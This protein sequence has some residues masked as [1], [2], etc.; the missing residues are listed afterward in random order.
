VLRLC[1]HLKSESYNDFPDFHWILR[2]FSL[3]LVD[4][5]GKALST[6]EY[7]EN[8]LQPQPGDSEVRNRIRLSIK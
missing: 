3:A 1:E 2:D 6:K 5:D 7:L 8:C 4:K